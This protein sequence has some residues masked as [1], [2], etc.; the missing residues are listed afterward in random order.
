VRRAIS[1]LAV[2]VIASIASIGRAPAAPAA[3]APTVAVLYFDYDGKRDEL[4][5]LK[6]GLA[7]MLISD[8]AVVEP[9]RVVERERLQALLDE[10]KLGQSGKIDRAT[11]VRVGKLLGA[12]MMILGGF[13][14]LGPSLRVDARLVDVETGRIIATSGATAK[15][16]EFIEVER[17]I[18]DDL[19]QALRRQA[20]AAPPT[21][22]AAPHPAR[23]ARPKPPAHLKTGTAIKYS[24]AL[25]AADK[26]DRAG[27]R[28]RLQGVLADEP[29]FHLARADLERMMQ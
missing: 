4:A 6:K 15:N 9:Y 1:F 24:Q 11:A 26:G 5:V 19:E 16:D 18:A 21:A 29:D 13:F 17:K 27:A 12:Q 2:I 3:P 25:A 7:Q 8:L 14:E 22:P 10:Q 20:A 28:T 23:T